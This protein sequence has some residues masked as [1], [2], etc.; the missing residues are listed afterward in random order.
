MRAAV[1]DRYGGPDVLSV[2]TVPVPRL[3]AAE[4]LIAV[5]AAGVGSWDPSL[6]NGEWADDDAKFP[7]ILGSDGS[8]TVVAVGSR[9]YRIGVGD[10]VYSYSIQNPKGGFYAEYVAVSASKVARVP[11]DLDAIRAAAVPAIGLTALQGVDDTLEIAAGERVIIHGASGNVGMLA[12]QF[13]KLRGA[14]VLATAS[15][16]DG[17]ELV[18]GLG[19]DEAIDGRTADI[20]A[21]TKEFAPDGVDALLAFVGGEEL[22]RC[23]DAVKEGG[24][25]AYPNGIEPEPRK[26]RGLRIKSYNAEPGVRP[27][28]RLN[29]AVEESKLEVPI[30][31]TFPL[32]DVALAHE[33]IERGHVLGRVVLDI[34]RR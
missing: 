15:G 8:G 31:A 19:A 14:R 5:D 4:V 16:T 21:A 3:N 12:V 6:R 22:T 26:R 23:L 25:L 11:E 33:R 30:A 7:L 24:R 20:E 10:R 18:R 32:K 28:E 29:A 9:V 27:M 1:I 17:V 34:S 13:A 2:Q